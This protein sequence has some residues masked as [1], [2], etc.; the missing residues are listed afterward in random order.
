MYIKALS[1]VLL[2]LELVTLATAAVPP[3]V[4][5]RSFKVERVRNDAYTGRNGPRALAKVYRKYGMPLPPGLVNALEAQDNPEVA[6]THARRRAGKW[7]NPSEQ[8]SSAAASAASEGDGEA[9]SSASSGDGHKGESAA[10]AFTKGNGQAAASSSSGTSNDT[11]DAP[12][13]DEDDDVIE[14]LARAREGNGTG[15]VVSNPER[16]DVEY[17]SQVKI[18]GQPVTLDFDTG[19]SDLWVFNTQLSADEIQ[20]RQVYDPTKSKTF[21]MMPGAKFTIRYGDGSGAEGNVGTDVVDVGGAVAPKQAVELA[22]AVTDTFVRDINNGGLMGLAFGKI[23]AV[24]PQ[25]QKTFFENVMPSLAEPLFTADLRAN[26]P[27]AY[28]FGRIDTSKFTGQM[29][30]IPVDTSKGFWQFSTQSFAV[31]GGPPQQGAQGGQ[32]IADTGTTLILADPTVVNGYYSQVPEAQE[33]KQ[34]GGFVVPCNAKLPDLDLDIGGSYMA[35]IKGKDINFAPVG[36]GGKCLYPNRK[37]ERTSCVVSL[38]CG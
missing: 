28:E 21:Q 33:S 9:G 16:N 26:A 3:Y 37:V 22:T 36:N 23:N 27:G 14:A 13:D 15:K 17:L 34:M 11:G 12:V 2:L 18:G 19:S 4:E 35:R 31:N 20:G 29:A 32:A 24:K 7:H 30:W 6:T 25:K 10:S 8:S 38:T 5:K 1:T